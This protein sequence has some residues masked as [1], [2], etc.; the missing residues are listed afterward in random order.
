MFPAVR[1][2]FLIVYIISFKGLV[3]DR[4]CAVSILAM[5][6]VGDL[7]IEHES[8]YILLSLPFCSDELFFFKGVHYMRKYNIIDTMESLNKSNPLD[9]P[10]Q[11]GH[12]VLDHPRVVE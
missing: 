3:T 11:V 9:D 6:I 7:L 8:V 1:S 2:D 10:S 5:V 12:T 4:F